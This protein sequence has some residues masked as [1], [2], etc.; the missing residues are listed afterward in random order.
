MVWLMCTMSLWSDSYAA[1]EACTA[2][3]LG[4][5]GDAK[6]SPR[7]QL[8]SKLPGGKESI[9]LAALLCNQQR[10]HPPGW[11]PA[12]AVLTLYSVGGGDCLVFG[13]NSQT[14]RKPF[15]L[16]H[17]LT[18]PLAPFVDPTVQ[19]VSGW[20]KWRFTESSAEVDDKQAS[21]RY[22]QDILVVCKVAIPTG[23]FLLL[24][25][26]VNL[27][28]PVHRPCHVSSDVSARRGAQDNSALHTA[29]GSA[30]QLLLGE[31]ETACGCS[32]G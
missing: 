24:C 28:K 13:N 7:M 27:P 1:A 26:S 19:P 5:H 10:R 9:L 21:K 2:Q 15:R 6:R 23:I 30:K 8:C 20:G 17:F 4:T 25:C 22:L 18:C 12:P 11:W 32:S 3:G 29:Q 31:Q 14:F 16:A